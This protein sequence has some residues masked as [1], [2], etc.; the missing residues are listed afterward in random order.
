MR[1]A[2]VSLDPAAFFRRRRPE[3]NRRIR[4][5][6]TPALPLGYVAL[7][8]RERAMGF[9]PMTFSLARRRSTTKLRP[10]TSAES[11][12]RTGDTLIFSQVLYRLSYLGL[13]VF[14]W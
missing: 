8:E 6:Q 7:P 11:Q 9:E 14:P 5:L 3:L 10:Q 13:I 12:T 2:L 4:V 1:L